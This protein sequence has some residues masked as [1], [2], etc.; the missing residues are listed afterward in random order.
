[1]SRNV[2][3]EP[4]EVLELKAAYETVAASEAG[5]KVLKH[6]MNIT[7]YHAYLVTVDPN[8]FEINMNATLRNASMRDVWLEIRKYLLPEMRSKIEES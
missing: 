4:K 5:R 8:S 7:G 6:I 3:K 1:M 2:L